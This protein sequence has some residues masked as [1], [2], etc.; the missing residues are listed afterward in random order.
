MLLTLL[1]KV[2]TPNG[3]GALL[4]NL[5]AAVVDRV[6]EKP[7]DFSIA[8]NNLSVSISFAIIVSFSLDSIELLPLA[9]LVLFRFDDDVFVWEP[10]WE[11][12]KLL[13]KDD[14]EFLIDSPNKEDNDETPWIGGVGKDVPLGIVVGDKIF[15]CDVVDDDE[16]KLLVLLTGW[17]LNV[18]VVDV[19]DDGVIGP[20]ITDELSFGWSVVTLLIVIDDEVGLDI[21]VELLPLIVASALLM[22]SYETAYF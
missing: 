22:S 11:P 12:D 16:F 19:D 5:R 6:S 9:E 15:A 21:F 1:L 18:D 20:L 2:V 13:L 4:R 14:W 8:F 17:K 7:L 3:Y 10:I